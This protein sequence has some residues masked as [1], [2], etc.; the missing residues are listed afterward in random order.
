MKSIITLFIVLFYSVLFSQESNNKKVIQNFEKLNVKSEITS[1]DIDQM[2]T[3]C[4][5]LSVYDPDVA[6][7][8]LEKVKVR[9][10]EI[11]DIENIPYYCSQMTRNYLAKNQ[12][13]EGL[14]AIE[15][16][17]NEYEKELDEGQKIHFQMNRLT[18]MEQMGSYDDCLLLIKEIL[19]QTEFINN[20]DR[21]NY[22]TV[23]YGIE[24]GCY[25]KKRG[26]YKLAAESYLKALRLYKEDTSEWKFVNIANIYN[27]LGKLY[28]DVKEYEKSVSYYLEGVNYLKESGAD[29][30]SYSIDLLILYSNLAN[31]YK[32]SADFGEALDYGNKALELAEK[33]GAKR[34]ESR[35]LATIGNTYME[36]KDFPTALKYLETSL[37][38]CCSL[39]IDEGI[40]YNYISLGEGYTSTNRYHNA[41]KAYDS[42]LV[43]VQKLAIPKA[44]VSVYKGYADLYT[45]KGDLHKA[46]EFH[47][48]FYELDKEL[49]GIE[50]QEA[51]AELE[52]AYQTELKD[53]E[54]KRISYEYEIKKAENKLIIIGAASVVLITAIFIFF[55]INRNQT[56]RKLYE[57]N[58]ELMN[59]FQN[60]TFVEEAT[61]AEETEDN[62]NNNFL[63]VF[64]K[65]LF[66]LE[67]EKIYKD[68]D[69]SLS[70]VSEIIKS[71]E[72]Y[73]SSAIAAHTKMNYSNFINSYRINE[74]KMLLYENNNLNI[75]EVMYACG[76]NSK[77]TFYEAFKKLTGMS[78]KQFKDMK[79]PS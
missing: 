42:A 5:E 53:E 64:N 26:K 34:H 79:V 46:L 7:D 51:I 4:D 77:T 6:L 41:Q 20:D 48:K 45:Q 63:N 13:P 30:E 35:I 65:L 11:N 74:A 10:K 24:G 21:I 12:L 31:V 49:F 39:G 32:E 9:I 1:Q 71:N 50:K 22:Q 56:L 38:M 17:Y 36:M 43:Y 68:P 73:I 18:I 37:N 27:R 76:F 33:T 66:A 25:A 60:K 78:P 29:Q 40:M 28:E 15:N 44:E 54:I 19:P 57:R 55:L 52:I 67:K 62:E 2:I 3:L 61:V 69:L 59:S 75:N 70:K 58:V 72:R 23:L 8:Y 14:K 47:N 16:L